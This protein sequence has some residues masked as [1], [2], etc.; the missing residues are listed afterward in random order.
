MDVQH[1]PGV[2]TDESYARLYQAI[3]QGD[4]LPNERLIEL[5]LAQAYGV[6]RATIRTR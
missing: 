2:E 3:V 4:L 1:T 5:D 6:G